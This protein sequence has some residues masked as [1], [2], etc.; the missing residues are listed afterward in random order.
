MLGPIRLALVLAVVIA[1][2]GGAAVYFRANAEPTEQH[3]TAD[4]VIQAEG[5]GNPQA[6]DQH[7]G[8]RV[9]EILTTTDGLSYVDANTTCE[10]LPGYQNRIPFGAGVPYVVSEHGKAIFLDAN[11]NTMLVA[12]N[13]YFDGDPDYSG[14]LI[15]P[16]TVRPLESEYHALEKC[17]DAPRG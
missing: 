11:G 2:A 5:K 9:C 6:I 17:E 10:V 14:V 15:G 7:V 8:I 16:A 12:S 1:L 4:T 3:P 13:C